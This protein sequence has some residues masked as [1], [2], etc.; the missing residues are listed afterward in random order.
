LSDAAFEK[1]TEGEKREAW[2]KADAHARKLIKENMATIITN[3][4]RDGI[5]P[6]RFVKR[7]RERFRF[8]WE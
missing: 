8:M 3:Q 1:A 7:G 2:A 4:I 6:L 5:I